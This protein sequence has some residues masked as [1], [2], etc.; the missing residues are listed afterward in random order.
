MGKVFGREQVTILAVVAAVFQVVTSYGFDVNGHVQGYITAV[1]VF[2]F[3]VANAIHV[4]DGIVALVV[5]ILNALFAV[6][7]AFN[8]DWTAGHQ[9]Y[10]IGA[11]TTLL[12]LFVRQVVV[13]PVPADVS[14]AGKLVSRV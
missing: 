5:G 9:A 2:V 11:V 3:A 14:P 7:A 12:G 1:V 10:I 4:H 8:L 13:A 6:F